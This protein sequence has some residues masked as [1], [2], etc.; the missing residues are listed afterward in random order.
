MGT[1]KISAIHD[2]AWLQPLGLVRE[3]ASPLFYHPLV[4]HGGLEVVGW[5]APGGWK[6]EFD[7]DMYCQ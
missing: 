3:F 5:K 7:R 4:P 1:V 6:S 2:L